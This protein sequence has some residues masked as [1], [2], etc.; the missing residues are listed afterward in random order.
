MLLLA[1][2]L[3]CILWN[4]CCQV[5]PSTLSTP[6]SAGGRDSTEHAQRVLHVLTQRMHGA[7]WAAAVLQPPE[8]DL[9]IYL[10]LLAKEVCA[11]AAPGSC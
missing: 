1:A 4:V 6:W 3:P 9:L 2:Q 11:P 10:D 7:D 8:D 5:L